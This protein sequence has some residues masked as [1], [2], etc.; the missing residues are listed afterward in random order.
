M[1]F[2]VIGFLAVVKHTKNEFTIIIILIIN[3]SPFGEKH[4]NT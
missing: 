1:C 2:P 4:H 3:Y